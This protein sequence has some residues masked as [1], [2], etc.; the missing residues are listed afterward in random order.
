MCVIRFKYVN[1]HTLIDLTNTTAL[2]EIILFEITTKMYFKIYQKL[3][4]TYFK[5]LGF[6]PAIIEGR[7]FLILVFV[8]QILHERI[9]A[10]LVA[11]AHAVQIRHFLRSEIND[12]KA[13]MDP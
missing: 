12:A 10:S 11:P 1:P 4:S 3:Y 2:L 6:P 9:Q 8:L 7:P 13:P 5:T